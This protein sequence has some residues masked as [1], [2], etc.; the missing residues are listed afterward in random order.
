GEGKVRRA[1]GRMPRIAE[2]RAH[3][4]LVLELYWALLQRELPRRARGVRLEACAQAGCA[5]GRRS[6]GA[7]LVGESMPER[8]GG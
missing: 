7:S 3:V 4:H 5:P 1:G 2:T 6:P 8:N